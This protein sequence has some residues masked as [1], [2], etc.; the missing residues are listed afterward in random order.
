[1]DVALRVHKGLRTG[2]LGAAIATLVI[3]GFPAAAGADPEA[4][5]KAQAEVDRLGMEA[6]AL[7][8]EALAAQG[9]LDEAKKRLSS[10]ESDTD[11]Q[12]HKVALMRGQIGQ[13]ALAQFQN[14]DLNPTTQL[15][16][17]SDS[18][19]FLSQFA[20]IQ[21]VTANQNG[22]L[23]DFQAQQANLADM[24]RG[25]AADVEKVNESTEHVQRARDASAEKLDQAERILEQL[26]AE[27]RARLQAE[28]ERRAREAAAAAE[29]AEAERVAA[30]RLAQAASVTRNRDREPVEP[31]LPGTDQNRPIEPETPGTEQNRPP[32]PEPAAS[33][34]RT[35]PQQPAPPAEDTDSSSRGM[36]ALAF[37]RGQ[38]GKPY[39]WGGQ[40]PSGF[41]CSGLTGAAW[42]SAG[43]SLPRTS[44]AQ[45][46]VG[47]AVAVSDLKPG[48]LV[49]Y[50]SGIS[51]VA[52]YAGGGQILHASR[53]GKPI[54]YAAL[55]SMPIA[56]ARRIG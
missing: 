45:Y 18:R 8:Q 35:Q 5:A 17:R 31:A 6:A 39:L 9:E 3:A 29:R 37:A 20:T 33:P 46:A 12:S 40:G 54:G 16:L 15:L 34:Q 42:R 41:D 47:R 52:L 10:R 2:V 48:D 27:E 44:Q 21:Q 1:M 30:D 14:R 24:E 25:A 28:E 26:T 53:P 36:A 49:F 4:V 32:A 19:S 7:D 22:V 13:V 23:Q 51:H 55:D 43:V 50:N 11:V 38:M 56:G